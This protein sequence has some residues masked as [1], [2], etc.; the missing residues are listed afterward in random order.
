MFQCDVA[1]TV[2]QNKAGSYH[3]QCKDGFE[4]NLDCRPVLNLGLSDGGI[5]DEAITASGE[6]EGMESNNYYLCVN[7]SR[8]I[9]YKNT[10]RVLSNEDLCKFVACDAMEGSV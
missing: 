10:V 3:C 7:M 4:P 5:P 8:A 1:S 2:C 9:S 6:E